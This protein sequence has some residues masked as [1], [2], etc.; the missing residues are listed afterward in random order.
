MAFT[1]TV[2]SSDCI[3]FVSRKILA[4]DIN[5]DVHVKHLGSKLNRS[6]YVIQYPEGKASV[7]ILRNMYFG[8]VHSH[9]KCSTI[10]G[11][12]DGESNKM[13]KLQDTCEV[14]QQC[15]KRYF[16]QGTVE[17]IKYTP[18]PMCVYHRDCILHKNEHR[19]VRAEFN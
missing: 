2:S 15:R 6:Y 5:W 4:E 3:A 13:L 1:G 9:L 11:G 18:S 12:S 10:F 17:D 19:L 14:N 16:L 7:S 8:N